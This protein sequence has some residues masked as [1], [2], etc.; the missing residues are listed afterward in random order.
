MD[1][2]NSSDKNDFNKNNEII[3]I[4]KDKETNQA[5]R[6]N[7][8]KEIME[9]DRQIITE[10]EEHD[11]LK[12]IKAQ[13]EAQ[14]KQLEQRYHDI[15][16]NFI[17]KWET[18][19]SNFEQYF[20]QYVSPEMNN[21]FN[22]PCILLFQDKVVLIFKFL[23]K[24]FDY[25]KDQLKDIPIKTLFILYNFSA[26]S[27]SL[28]FS[29]NLPNLNNQINLENYDLIE[30][31]IFYN[32]FKEFVPNGEIENYDFDLNNNCI[33]KYLREYLFSIGFYKNFFNDFLPRIDIPYNNFILFSNYAFKLLS[34]CEEK[35]IKKNDYNLIL[36]E[37]F[38]KKMDFYIEHFNEY[39]NQ[40]KNLLLNE[41]KDFLNQYDIYIFGGL[42]WTFDIEKNN[43][44]DIAENFCFSIFKVFEFFLKHQKLEL[45]IF[46]IEK[47]TYIVNS[48]DKMPDKHKYNDIERVFEFTKQKFIKFLVKINI[49]DLIFGE[50]IHEAIIGRS[51]HVLSFLY[52]YK[53]FTAEQIS[54]LWKISQSKYQSIGND[55][56]ILFGKLLPEFSK[57]DC[58]NI[59]LTV[60]NMN[61][62]EVNEITLK[63]LENFYFSKEKHETLLH[64]LFKY[65]NELCSKYGLSYAFIDKSR[66]IL[67][68]LLTNPLYKEDFI[69][70][71]KNCLF[72]LDNNYL[73]STHLTILNKIMN[74][75][76]EI[77][78]KNQNQNQNNIA[79]ETIMSIS[80]M[81]LSLNDQLSMY[82]ILIN[83][84]MKI[85]QFFIFL[86]EESLRLGKLI[87]AGNFDFDS[88][89]NADKLAIKFQGYKINDNDINEES[90]MQLDS[91]NLSIED[92]SIGYLL[93]KS[94]IDVENYLKIILNEFIFFFK[95]KLLKEKVDLSD[96]EIINNLFT[97]FEFSFKENTFGKVINQFLDIIFSMN[98]LTNNYLNR[99]M[100]DILYKILVENSLLMKE[101]E[102]FYQFLKKII[103][104]QFNNP[105]LNYINEKDIEYICLERISSN[106]IMNLPT[107]SYEI[108]SLYFKYI[109]QKNNN[110]IYSN[111]A[112]IT[113][114][115]RLDL[116]VGFKTIL[117][118][119]I[120]SKDLNQVIHS[121]ILIN[122]I[123][124]VSA[125]DLIKRKYLLDI[126]FNL[127]KKNKS[128]IKNTSTNSIEKTGF[129][130]ILRLISTVNKVKVSENLY[131]AN[132]PNN[133]L[134]IKINNSFFI[135]N[136][137]DL[138][139]IKIFKGMTIIEFKEELINKFVCNDPLQINHL[140]NFPI[141]NITNLSQL[142]SEIHKNN[143]VILYYK[144]YILKDDFTLADYNIESNDSIKIL[145][146]IY[147]DINDLEFK[148]TDQQLKEGYEAIKLVFNNQ[149]N[150]EIMKEALYKFKGDAE[151]A[152]TFMTEENNI[153]SLIHE[154]EEKKKN[155]PKKR[156]EI[157]CLEEDK[158]NLLL[159]ILNEGDNDLNSSIWDLFSEIK[160]PDIFVINAIKLFDNIMEENN[161]NKKIL[162]LKII[163]SVIFGDN[164]FCKNNKI[165]DDIKNEWI[166]K[167]VNNDIFIGQIL[168]FLSK[169]NID[170]FNQ[171]N[172]TKIISIII[173]W[174]EKIFIKI[175][176]NNSSKE[177]NI[178]ES[179][180]NFNIIIDNNNTTEEKQKNKNTESVDIRFELEESQGNN[181]I[182]ILAKNN[183]IHSIYTILGIVLEFI[184]GKEENLIIKCI[185]NI[186]IGYLEI[187]T[188]DIN[189]FLEEEK[190]QKIILKVLISSLENDKIEIRKSSID[191]FKELMN[192]TKQF[193][194]EENIVDIQ[195]FLLTCYYPELISGEI[196]S[197][198]FYEIYNFLINFER[199][200][201]N[202]IPMD[203]MIDKFLGNIFDF[204]LN[205]QN[206]DN[207]PEN[208]EKIKNNIKYNLYIL[209]CLHPLYDDL[210]E[211]AIEK[212]FQE[213]KDI[214][215]TLYNCLFKIEKNNNNDNINLLFSDDQLRGNS[216]FFLSILISQKQK[217]FNILFPK[218]IEH[219]KS[220]PSNKVDLPLGSLFRN[221][222]TQKFIGLKNYGA[223]CYL[224]SLFQQM[225][226]IPTFYQDLFKFDITE[227]N[228]NLTDST[229]Y[230]MQLTFTNLKK[231]CMQYYTPIKFIHS[232]K[233]AFNGEPISLGTQQDTDEFLSILCDKLEK[234]A[235]KYG[236][237]NFLEN[238]FKG[239]ITNEI[240]SLE[241]EHPYYSQTEEP[242]YRITLDIKGHKNLEDA[243]D[244]YIQGEI[245]DG[246]NKYFV[247][248]YN[249]KISIKKRTTIKKI[250]NQ[251][252]IH[253]K[254]FEFNFVTFQNFKLNDYLKFPLKLNFKKWTRAYL[255]M[256]EANTN[257]MNDNNI[258]S[259]EEQE[260]LN[261]EKMNYELTG[262]LVHSGATLKSGHYYSFIKDQ[263]TNKWYKFN[264]SQITE[265]DIDK[266]LEKEC[267]GNI[268]N[269]I[270]KYGKGAYLLFYTKKECIESNK[271]FQKN[272]KINENIL[273]EVESENINFI[274]IKT[275]ANDMYHRF[276]INIINYSLQY[277]N[278]ADLDIGIN[279][280]D[281][282]CSILISDEMKQEIKIY[283]KLISILKGNK[284]NKIDLNDNEFKNL[285]E[286]ME[287]IYEKCKDEIT[288][289][290][291]NDIK[292]NSF[293]NGNFSLES[294]IKLFYFFT[295]GIAYQYN[296]K[297][298]N[299]NELLY[300][301]IQ[302]L[303]KY[304]KY[305]VFIMKM[306]EKDINIFVDLLFKY[307][308]IDKEMKRI[309][310]TIKSLYLI[311]FGYIYNFEREKYHLITNET[312]CYFTK[313]EKGKFRVEKEYKSLF[314]RLFHKLFC[315]NLEKC[316]EKFNRDA[317][318][319]NLFNSLIS[320]YPE[321]CHV[322]SNY[323]IS[324][325]SFI[326]NNNL[327]NFKS[328]KNPNFK[329]GNKDSVYYPNSLYY[330]SF[331][332]TILRC[333][334]DGMQSSKTISPY[335]I[336]NINLNKE[337]PDFS[338]CPKLPS[339]WRRIL[340]S[341]FFFN[342]IMFCRN[343]DII[344]IF[345]HLSFNDKDVTI[346]GMKFMNGFLKTDQ[347][348]CENNE[349]YFSRIFEI[350]SIN[351]DLKELRIK[352]LYDLNGDV[353][354]ENSLMKFYFDRKDL[355]PNITLKGIYILAKIIL[356][357]NIAYECFKKN[358]KKIEWI[359]NYNTEAMTKTKDQNGYFY[360]IIQKD[361]GKLNDLFQV[362]DE[363]IK[364][365]EI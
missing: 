363:L 140:G 67:V 65:S 254:R 243:L 188:N 39:L 298:Q 130:K 82:N 24:Y 315:S 318:F 236:K 81:I 226:M 299:I 139:P 43:L 287:Q 68:K 302:I 137:T 246:D 263:E 346:Y 177:T 93:P 203:E 276:I 170:E 334:T 88:L 162:I 296:D 257:E 48:Y 238:S 37:V 166:S 96:N 193:K 197:E 224:N 91:D 200:K 112:K 344:K 361:L 256:N 14:I 325:I 198:E 192:V 253:L 156:E 47:F 111:D 304:P 241:D 143:L 247:E 107:S 244:A 132:D 196:Y 255:R 271:N 206:L 290:K 126:L 323:L 301:L 168:D 319:L 169:L 229:I 84:L 213:N 230:N 2:P 282:D 284:E 359:K 183:F 87:S 41:M 119:H 355:F 141:P 181:F 131:D 155:E 178:N 63:L 330:I 152:I 337:N 80:A 362:I 309:N 335:F 83:H 154:I 278:D 121:L 90:K 171:Y 50:N 51:Y 122:N 364:K 190:Q 9:E 289:N 293:K 159:D 71:I 283:E 59:L 85:K 336:T 212:N 86:A 11:E 205:N 214:I 259:K 327:P 279:V 269:S 163:N 19:K 38:T 211:N 78:K 27:N 128:K 267:F 262:I 69:K 321:L 338:L 274:K 179:G 225:F 343:N 189:I 322:S 32:I 180:S 113:H 115:R 204:Y 328:E 172:Y 342:Y 345:Y 310:N 215:I 339:N 228:E 201:P 124:E 45:R 164:T 18:D 264:D 272:I 52:K 25:L 149:Y 118:F 20:D 191:F 277:L 348:Y 292:D 165:D 3:N 235:K 349:I 103:E 56:I 60:Y 251:I 5:S 286:N 232:F 58:N 281:N 340:D 332:N 44:E 75:L 142:K 123:I 22:T 314:L 217:Y 312:F 104:L 260:N 1:G 36:I 100:I 167:F 62:N 74:E 360:K 57:E 227:K 209:C 350:L 221:F 311:L 208:L 72:C 53:S 317:L 320:I 102:I 13:K 248:K 353:N 99:N 358:I 10:E 151:N 184:K 288:E 15:L 76:S 273:R 21:M 30:D 114:I 42:A 147:I 133:M 266:D 101:K 316:R 291:E 94:K 116:L 6:G 329:M 250:G 73:L 8:R 157:I 219:H 26:S 135:L 106:E 127:L 307:I 117:D 7:E 98:E 120:S 153:Q 239:K 222:D 129:R 33:D 4:D 66:N 249:K 23:C 55:I 231:S 136:N 175:K 218:I 61:Y 326:T 176:E 161:L 109:N 237:E 125:K 97:N 145:N 79:N 280:N 220:I 252:I 150:E 313:D 270:N 49:F 146:R 275:F 285:P 134:D 54:L 207:N 347:S 46:G 29:K 108:L 265:Y 352:I 187:K 202:T 306:I 110:I 351:D 144:S 173:N 186:L 242:F 308:F 295:F 199:I 356:Q 195:S 216:F 105:Y 182:E 357:N 12:K 300:L 77:K 138:V 240:V 365:L 258:I 305:I 341:Q 89:L 35:F 324:L 245:L 40:S 194:E 16:D 223:T 234:E 303:Q 331:T 185:Y 210:L 34:H 148:M 158:F 95:N 294:I 261:E 354:E 297:D 31:K 17:I 160:F 333:V 268:D 64:I 233:N 28:L 174:L 92:N 70:C